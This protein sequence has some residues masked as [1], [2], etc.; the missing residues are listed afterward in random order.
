MNSD[1]QAL[2][3]VWQRQQPPPRLAQEL[4]KRV[5]Q[6]RRRARIHR[7]AEAAITLAGVALLAWPGPDGK[8][9]PSQWLLIPFFAVFIAIG[10]TIAIS[11]KRRVL[12]AALEPVAMY[13]EARKAQLRDSAR[14]LKV[15]IGA[16]AA[17]LV[18]SAAALSVSLAVGV[19]GWRDA[20]TGVVVWAAVWTAG[21]FLL[22]R[23]RGKAI[24]REYRQISR[25][26]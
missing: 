3:A 8:L 13:A 26:A 9:S 22:A 24:R 12:A 6:H 19:D 20:A 5:E 25:L 7:A 23:V 21:T 16:S 4:A 2:R 11:N 17:L 10:W 15:A 14:H 1:E 18:Y